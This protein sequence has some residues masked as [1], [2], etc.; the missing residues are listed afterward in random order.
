MWERSKNFFRK[1]LE[2]RPSGKQWMKLFIGTALIALFEQ[3]INWFNLTMTA[4]YWL[5]P[6]L[7]FFFTWLSEV[8][9][10]SALP[11]NNKYFSYAATITISTA[12]VL[13]GEEG[14]RFVI[15]IYIIFSNGFNF[16][17]ED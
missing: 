5:P 7:I 9:K 17:I 1:Y 12:S 10:T 15:I 13:L 8:C 3:V 2:L 6:F 14:G 16:F 4:D 11:K